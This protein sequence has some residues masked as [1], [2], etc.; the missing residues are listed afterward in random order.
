HALGPVLL[1]CDLLDPGT[2]HVEL[3]FADPEIGGMLIA[4]QGPQ[5]RS[6]YE[7]RNLLS[8]RQPWLHPSL[9]ADADAPPARCLA[10]ITRQQDLVEH[11]RFYVLAP[12]PPSPRAVEP[13]QQ[14][15][16]QGTCLVDI[17]FGH[18]TNPACKNPRSADAERGHLSNM[19]VATV[20][21]KG[22][23]QE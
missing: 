21:I 9:H 15:R 1:A 18:L 2:M 20:P 8:R 16:Y 13:I 17:I 12:F 10:R 23:T 5:Y 6:P 7:Y 22:P 3:S 4:T 19:V 14:R 11:R